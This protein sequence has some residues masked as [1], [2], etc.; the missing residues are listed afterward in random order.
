MTVRDGAPRSGVLVRVRFRVGEGGP[1]GG[2]WPGGGGPAPGG[3][4]SWRGGKDTRA[5]R[6]KPGICLSL[7]RTDYPATGGES[8]QGGGHGGRVPPPAAGDRGPAEALGREAGEHDQ[9]GQRLGQAAGRHERE[10]AAGHGIVQRLQPALPLVHGYPPV[11]LT[12]PVSC[13]A[14]L[15]G[16]GVM[17]TA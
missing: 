5:A 8:W 9:G 11:S 6:R 1:G 16:P 17:L 4:L 3:R 2:R 14:P 13:P 12:T 7:G 10:R 15:C